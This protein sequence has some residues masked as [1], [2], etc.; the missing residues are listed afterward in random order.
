MLWDKGVLYQLLNNKGCKSDLIF[1][2]V[3]TVELQAAVASVCGELLIKKAM[4][5]RD[6]YLALNLFKKKYRTKKLTNTTF[7]KLPCKTKYKQSIINH[8]K[9]RFIA[10]QKYFFRKG[11]VIRNLKC[12]LI[13]WIIS[14][15]NGNMKL[16]NVL[17]V[18]IYE[19]ANYVLLNIFVLSVPLLWCF[20]LTIL[21]RESILLFRNILL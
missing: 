3:F 4:M 12:G 15:Q 8:C 16:V 13:D 2:K 18:A 20:V 19:N 21:K 5:L 7:Q 1:K 17:P 11:L 9:V 10:A 14:N 6:H